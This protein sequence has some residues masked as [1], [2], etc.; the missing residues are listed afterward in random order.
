MAKEAYVRS[1]AFALVRPPFLLVATGSVQVATGDRAGG[2]CVGRLP[3]DRFPPF[4]PF[5]SLFRFLQ[6]ASKL[7]R[8]T[9]LEGIALGDYPAELRLYTP[10]ALM[11]W[12]RYVDVCRPMYDD[13]T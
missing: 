12:H 6:V 1:Q 8:A 4:P 9:G 2:H 7:Q 13:V 3:T 11:E 5:P 10:G